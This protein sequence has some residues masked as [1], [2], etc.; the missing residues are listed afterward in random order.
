MG[1][2]EEEG[3]EQEEDDAEGALAAGDG[4]SLIARKRA[5]IAW[6]PIAHQSHVLA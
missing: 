4:T 6:A 2:E 1:E 5:F 3:E